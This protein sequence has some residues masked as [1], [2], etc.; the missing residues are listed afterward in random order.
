MSMSADSTAW[1]RLF[2][3]HP[4]SVRESYGQ[5][6]LAACRIGMRLFE[7]G[8]ACLCHAVVPGVF[9]DTASRGVTQLAGEMSQR[10]CCAADGDRS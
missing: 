7:M 10:R 1:Q 8:A 9:E 5:H 6:L 2:A 3:D 4:A